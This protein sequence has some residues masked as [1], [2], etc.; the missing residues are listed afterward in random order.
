MNN[1]RLSRQL[2]QRALALT[3]V[4]E[5]C[6]G[7]FAFPG[8]AFAA[9]T[10]QTL[11]ATNIGDTSA[12]FQGAVGPSSS[13]G[14]VSAWF[15]YGDTTSLG[16][17]TSTVTL[18][19]V[20]G[21]ISQT[22]SNLGENRTI[23]F[24]VVAEPA[25]VSSERVYGSLRS[26]VTGGNSGSRE[27]WFS[28]S[29]QGADTG[30]TFA[31]L[32][33]AVGKSPASMWIEWGRTTSFGQKTNTQTN[34]QP[35]QKL[36]FTISGLTAG[37]K[38]YARSGATYDGV[39]RYS[40]TISFTT[41]LSATSDEDN[42]PGEP[43]QPYQPTV[44]TRDMIPVG[45]TGAILQGRATNPKSGEMSMWFQW[46][47]TNSPDQV[48][49]PQRVSVNAFDFS[50]TIG[51]LTRGQRYYYRAVAQNN[52]G[53]TLGALLT[54]IAGESGGG[55]TS[56]GSSLTAATGPLSFLSDSY[57]T[58]TGTVQ[59]GD[60][61]ATTYVKWG[62]TE[63][64]LNKTNNILLTR[65]GLAVPISETLSPLKPTTRYFYQVIAIAD[66][67]IQSGVVRSFTTVARSTP[68]G[69]GAP[70]GG[71]TPPTTPTGD[72]SKTTIAFRAENLTLATGLEE[73]VIANPGDKLR[74]AVQVTNSG[75]TANKNVV[76]STEV[77]KELSIT[78]IHNG[79]EQK[80][81]TLTWE[82]PS[83]AAKTSTTLQFDATA[84]TANADLVHTLVASVVSSITNRT[85]NEV[86]VVLPRSPVVIA[87]EEDPAV[88]KRGSRVE[89]TF[90]VKNIAAEDM[91]DA[92]LAVTFADG[93]TVV[94]EDDFSGGNPWKADI[95]TLAEGKTVKKK[96][97]VEIPANAPDALVT[98]VAFTYR[99]ADGNTMTV[100]QDHTTKVTDGSAASASWCGPSWW[101]WIITMLLFIALVIALLTRKTPGPKEVKSDPPA[102]NLPSYK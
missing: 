25:G 80:N 86:H 11:N 98:K 64:M 61:P 68:T 15:E 76:V 67:N 40:R 10:A 90:S 8:A 94:K 100:T 57:A 51:G 58:V 21:D 87:V 27:T 101:W 45:T 17:T 24:R 37:T 75:A 18:P 7:T 14:N 78:T 36:F 56:Q 92:S 49:T 23:Y 59:V 2:M 42:F 3:I 69:G 5:L 29:L 44:I 53:S 97:T 28:V 70:T 47:T 62:E 79:G 63:E 77:P 72:G 38:Y 65:T 54:F 19:S 93:V 30:K 48:T 34:S 85:S 35:Y 46:G 60:R 26:F 89:Y 55:G 39:T 31:R 9:I 20:G 83:L 16:L 12:T 96:I 91:L 66:G 71:G 73:A 88:A 74:F 81:S 6:L 4:F 22:V 41:R 1:T 13:S 84:G 82:I 102:I 52:E 33:G 32:D 95:G 99:F 50:S 43:S